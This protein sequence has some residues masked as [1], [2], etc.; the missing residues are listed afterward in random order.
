MKYLFWLIVLIC[1]VHGLTVHALPPVE[2]NR[3]KKPCKT[4][5]DCGG[6]LCDTEEG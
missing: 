3:A 5:A 1:I 6:D 4:N 2:N